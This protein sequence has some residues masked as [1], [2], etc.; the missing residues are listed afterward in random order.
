MTKLTKTIADSNVMI[1]WNETNI[2]RTACEYPNC[3][4]NNHEKGL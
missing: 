2:S 1:A 4:L 3:F